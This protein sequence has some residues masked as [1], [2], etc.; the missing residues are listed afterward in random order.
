MTKQDFIQQLT[1]LTANE[2]VLAVSRDVNELRSKFEDFLI[3]ETRQRQVAELEAKDRGETPEEAPASDTEKDQFYEIFGAYKV[4]RKA[5]VEERNNLEAENLQKKRSLINKLKEVVANEE[6]IGAAFGAYKEIHE[7]WKNVGEIPRDKRQDVQNEYS[8]LLEDFFYNMKIYRE[9]KDY[10]LKKNLDL[11]LEVI[12][13]IKGLEKLTKIKDV[14]S[15]LKALQNDWEEIGPAT[16]DRW[17]EIKEA[18]WSNVK[19]VWERIKAFYDERREQFQV[20]LDRKKELLVEAK[21]IVAKENET[22]KDWDVNTKALI[23]LQN[24]WKEVGFGPKKEN[25]EVW[26]EFRA[27]CD[28]FFEAKSKFYEGINEIY[29]KAKVKKEALIAKVDTLKDSTDWKD[30]TQKIIQL[31]KD[32]KACGNAGNKNEQALWKKFRGA[33]DS[34]FNAKQKHFEDMDKQNEVN[35]VAK[36]EIIAKI[37]AYKPGKDQKQTVADL[38]AFSQS[39]NEAGKVPFKEKD[40]IY[41]EYKDLIDANYD[42]LK[43]E[44]AE[45]EKIMFQAKLDSLAA[46]PDPVKAYAS[47]KQHIRTQIDKLKQDVIQYENN[48]GFFA[49][50]KG[51]NALKDEV[52]KNIKGTKNKMDALVRKLKM[53]PNE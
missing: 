44:G 22:T 46:N 48:L 8:R 42:K 37:K 13:Q 16:Q 12:E 31:Q 40:R 53:I 20:N 34:F 27:E 41:K 43:L 6:N 24:T 11:K 35:L 5:I 4:K 36:E 21:E 17:E 30:T 26:H 47:E 45:K 25:E 32:W 39:F 23:A 29:D 33:C 52:E 15:K 14:E 3:E 9:I 38:K 1:E 28:S 18:Y 19:A 50:S 2:N 10:D 49:N 7:S 51:A